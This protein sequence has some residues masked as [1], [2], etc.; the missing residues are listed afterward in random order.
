VPDAS[1]SRWRLAA[2]LVII[3]LGL[4]HVVAV[5]LAAL[6]P[7]RYSENATGFTS[8]L[9]PYFNQNWRL[10]APNPISDD[11]NI[12]VQGAYRASD[13][14]VKT[15]DWID[16]T[17]VELDLVRHHVIGG[18]AG[19][20]TSKLY[21]PLSTWYGALGA[22]ARVANAPSDP[23]D[24]IPTWAELREDLVATGAT[25][26]AVSLYLCYDQATARLAT[27]IMVGRWPDHDWVA[28]RFAQR[29]QGVTPYSA[30]HGSETERERARPA[31]VLRVNGWRQPVHGDKSEQKSVA[32]FDRRH[33]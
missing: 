7:N 15:T 33:R 17:D 20:I 16:W 4:T 28:V 21:S 26:R 13:G 31:P 24:S 30:R 27:D 5:T 19:Y 25:S 3:L 23:S 18:R 1:T 6:P 32:S 10:F 9:R 22:A 29:R 11:R 14:S 8:Y 2:V 12:L